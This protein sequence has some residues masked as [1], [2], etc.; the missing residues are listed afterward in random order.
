MSREMQGGAKL[1]TRIATLVSQSIVY[2]HSKLIH[3]KHKLAM[4][5]FS[6]ISDIISEEVHGSLGPLLKQFHGELDDSSIAHGLIKFMATEHGQLQALAGSAASATG[7]FSSVAQVINNELAPSVR[8]ILATNPHLLPDPGTLAQLAAKGLADKRDVVGAITQQGINVGWANAIIAAEV[9]YPDAGTMLDMMRRGLIGRDNFLE[10]TTKQG[11]PIVIAEQWAN[12]INVPLSPGDAAL[13]LLRGNI[14]EE[15]ALKAAADA[16]MDAADFQTLVDNTGEPLGLMQ[17]LEAYRR[18]FINK[19]RLE[20]GIIQ[21]RVRN[22]WLDV[23]EM[24]RYSPISVADAVNAVI[25]GH[26]TQA[27]GDSISQQNGLQPGFF[28]TLL[29]TAGEPLSRTELEELYNRGKITEAQVKQGLLESRL[30]NKYTDDAF[31][32]HEKLLPIRNLS[33]AVEYGTMTLGAAVG[34]A[35]KNGYSQTDATSLILTASAR[36]LHQF[37]MQVVTAAETLLVDNAMDRATFIQVVLNHGF[38]EA[39]AEAI[40]EGAEYK[41]VARL[42]Q[43]AITAVRAK[44]LSRHIDKSEASGLLDGLGVVAA[45]RDQLLKVWELERSSMTRLLTHAEIIKAYKKG[46]FDAKETIS[47][48]IGLGFSE[49]DATLLVEIV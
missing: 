13:A 36:K 30:K 38:D 39:E 46:I 29:D 22:E 43:S 2:T 44:Y 28:Q 49:A 40:A 21:S 7:I 41:R 37:K 6:D 31:S 32:L 47:R 48:L 35:M 16:G 11:I 9:H 45:H 12:L 15:R 34:E 3:L 33:E 27:E 17:L 5:I 25:Q 18:G 26:L 4:K 10:W 8:G 42:T 24:L 23:A 1:G 19:Q 14:T 20:R